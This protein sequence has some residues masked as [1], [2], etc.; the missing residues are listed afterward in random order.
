MDIKI[1]ICH[2]Y[3]RTISNLAR[4]RHGFFPVVIIDALVF[5]AENDKCALDCNL[6]WHSQTM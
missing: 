2:K 6:I 4:T 3:N 1:C 5:Q